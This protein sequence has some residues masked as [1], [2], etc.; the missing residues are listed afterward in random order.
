MIEQKSEGHCSY[1]F[2]D[3]S[4]SLGRFTISYCTVSGLFTSYMNRG[5]TQYLSILVSWYLM[6]IPPKCSVLVKPYTPRD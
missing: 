6:G 1:A 5:N 3:R 4:V 2:S